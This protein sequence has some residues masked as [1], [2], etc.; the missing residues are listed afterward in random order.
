MTT[1]PLTLHA[2]E[3]RRLQATGKVTV[4]RAVKNLGVFVDTEM[5]MAPPTYYPEWKQWIWPDGTTADCPHAPG[6]TCWVRETWAEGDKEPCDCL[7][8]T[9]CRHRPM[10]HFRAD[11]AGIDDDVRWRPASHMPQWASRLSITIS[12]VSV[13]R[14]Q[15]IVGKAVFDAGFPFASDLDQLKIWWNKSNPKHQFADGPWAW[16]YVCEKV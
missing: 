13:Q 9:I 10:V 15:E 2:H 4:W 6:S 12:R 14:V 16:V 8:G 3:I 1:K 5:G 11:W 7:P